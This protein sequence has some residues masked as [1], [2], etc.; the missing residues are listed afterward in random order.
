MK[1]RI[2]ITAYGDITEEKALVYASKLLEALPDKKGIAQFNDGVWA[3][4]NEE[5]KNTT[6]AVWKYEK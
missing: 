4:Y 3:S 6:I 2:Y 5:A 1:K